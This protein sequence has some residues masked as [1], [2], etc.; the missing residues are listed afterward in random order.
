[1]PKSWRR[2][3]TLLAPLALA[4]M[5]GCALFSG[6]GEA[7]PSPIQVSIVAS[8]RL[9]PDDQGQA[10]PTVV[11]LYQLRSPARL[12]AAEFEALYRSE[13]ETLGED[14]LQVDEVVVEPGATA[15]R[16]LPRHKDARALAAV[17]LFRRPSGA[18]WRSAVELPPP[19]KAAS[20]AFTVEDYRIV[21][22]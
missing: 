14:L 5:A 3:A 21:R 7:T 19:G 2:G 16:K 1:M 11:R 20:F 15:A 17:G 9:N 10:L 8:A 12:E 22:R 13:K 4:A 6:G 18:S